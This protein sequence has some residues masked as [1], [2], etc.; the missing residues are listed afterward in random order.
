MPARQPWLKISVW[1]SDFSDLLPLSSSQI[2]IETMALPDYTFPEEEKPEEGEEEELTLRPQ[3][4]PQGS[5]GSGALMGPETQKGLK[6]MPT[7]I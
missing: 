3:P 5:G 7:W 1:C 2:E 4:I 6:N